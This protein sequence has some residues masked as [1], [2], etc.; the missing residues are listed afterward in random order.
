MQIMAEACVLFVWF[1][2]FQ[3]AYSRAELPEKKNSAW[4][5]CIADIFWFIFVFVSFLGGMWEKM[6]LL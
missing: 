5:F 2:Q 3:L 4:M 6:G 1:Q